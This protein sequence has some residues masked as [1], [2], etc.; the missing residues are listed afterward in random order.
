VKKGE[1]DRA[2]GEHQANTEYGSLVERLLIL[3]DARRVCEFNEAVRSK[4]E[5]SRGIM[6][7]FFGTEG[8]AIC[9]CITLSFSFQTG[10]CFL[11]SHLLLCNSVRP[12]FLSLCPAVTFLLVPHIIR[13]LV[14]LALFP[15]KFCPSCHSL[16]LLPREHCTHLPFQPLLTPFLVPFSR[17]FTRRCS[18]HFPHPLSQSHSQPSLP[19]PTT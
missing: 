16:R 7:Q 9:M 15:G 18:S 4:A 6:I 2:G 8:C 17:C 13:F 14:L 10:C 12:P 19:L 3:E 1:L 11:S 5:T